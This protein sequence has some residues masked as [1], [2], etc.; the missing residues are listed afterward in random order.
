MAVFAL[1]VDKCQGLDIRYSHQRIVCIV[2]DKARFGAVG[3]F[4][5]FFLNI[6]DFH[7]RGGAAFG[8]LVGQSPRLFIDAVR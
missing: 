3:F 5:M 6:V 8:V 4:D 1:V 2:N 7:Y